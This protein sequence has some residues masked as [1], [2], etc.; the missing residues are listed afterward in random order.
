MSISRRGHLLT[1]SF[2]YSV[3]PYFSRWDSGAG[4]VDIV[5]AEFR[6]TAALS[7]LGMFAFAAGASEGIDEAKHTPSGEAP[8]TPT[9]TSPTPTGGAPTKVCHTDKSCYPDSTTGKDVCVTHE[10]CE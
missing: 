2:S 7:P 5:G 6:L 3:G 1:D 10:V 8:R 4:N 9:S